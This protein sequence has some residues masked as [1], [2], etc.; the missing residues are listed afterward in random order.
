MRGIVSKYR[1]LILLA[2]LLGVIYVLSRISSV[3]LA[4]T[5]NPVDMKEADRDDAVLVTITRDGKFQL[6]GGEYGDEVRVI[7]A[8]TEIRVRN[9]S[10]VDLKD[11]VIDE[12]KFGDIR[13][14]EVTEYRK[15]TRARRDPS[16]SL[17]T[18]SKLLKTE[19]IGD[20]TENVLSHGR[21]TY[22]ITIHDAHLNVHAEEE[23]D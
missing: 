16:V 9:A 19:S 11:I 17:L 5:K 23:K 7:D 3:E 21:C 15:I 2:S 10:L 12:E 1:S 8:Q 6:G 14:D 4:K 22:V 13:R 20:G 18:N